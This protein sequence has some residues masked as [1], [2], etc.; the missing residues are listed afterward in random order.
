MKV[1]EDLLGHRIAVEIDERRRMGIAREELA[2]LERARR[3]HRAEDQD[4]AEALVEE[5]GSAEDEGTHQD[6]A[7]LRVGL[8]EGEQPV[9]RHLDHLA[10]RRRANGGERAASSEHIKLAG[11]RAPTIRRDELF[12]VA[13]CTHDDE[14]SIG[15]D[16][17]RILLLARI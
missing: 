15:D 6:R 8:D 12:T 14:L 7:Q 1:I 2:N 10:W 5:H 9:S 16:E 13:R 17:E 3:K 4:I 11:E